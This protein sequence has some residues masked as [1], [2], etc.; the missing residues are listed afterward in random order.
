MTD[1]DVILSNLKVLIVDDEIDIIH[2]IR[3]ILHRS[4]ID[5]A[6]TFEE[7][8]SKLENE[9][10]DV[11]ILDIMGVDGYKLLDIA[12]SKEIPTLMLT[13]HAFSISDFNKSL[14]KG[15]HAYIPKEKVTDIDLFIVDVL[16]ADKKKLGR[17]GKWF[18]RLEPFFEEK[19]GYY[20][21]EKVK[22]DPEFWREVY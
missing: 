13:A 19:F 7:A 3:E 2:T 12:S 22:E 1:K 5:E 14:G 10:Y 20:W 11:V 15:A 21:K 8:K 18:Q 16:E 4:S 6:M 17:L 9:T